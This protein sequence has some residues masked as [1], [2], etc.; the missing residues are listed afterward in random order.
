MSELTVGHGAS[1]PYERATKNEN[2][3]LAIS[4]VLSGNDAPTNPREFLEDWSKGE[5]WPDYIKYI[6]ESK[7]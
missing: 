1:Y 2:P 6:E 7:L 3:M 5:Y 4:F